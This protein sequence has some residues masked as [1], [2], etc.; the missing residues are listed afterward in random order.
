MQ[1]KD[2]KIALL[3]TYFDTRRGRGHTFA[4]VN[5]VANT[6]NVTVVVHNL[7][8]GKDIQR[9]CQKKINLV[10]WDNLEGLRNSN[11][12]LVIDNAAISQI[13]GDA[14]DMLRD[15]RAENSRLRDKLRHGG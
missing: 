5:G 13:L 7:N 3:K 9:M 1:N 6:E 10:S 12:A 2:E 11:N 15:L 4:M 14:L 8:Y